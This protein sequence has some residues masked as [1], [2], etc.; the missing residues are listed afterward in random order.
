VIISAGMIFDKA[1]FPS[2]HAA[3]LVETA[4]GRMLAAWFGGTAE[5]AKDVKIWASTYDGK[6]WSAPVVAAEEPGQPT[7]NPVLFLGSKKTLF[8]FYKAGPSPERWSGFVRRSRDQGRTWSKAEIL[9]AGLLGPIKNK[10]IELADGV[11]LAPTSVESYRAWCCW[12]ERSS[13]DGRTWQRHGP[14]A[15]PDKPHG[16]IQPTLLVTSKGSILALCRSRGIG[17]IC[18]AESKDDGLTWSDAKPTTLPNPNSGIDAVRARDWSFYLVYNPTKVGRSPLVLARSVDDGQ[19]WK[20]VATLDEMLLGEFSYPAIIQAGDGRLHMAWTWNR[21]HI[22][23]AVY[24]P[25][26]K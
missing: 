14:I 8:L 25:G 2:C 4:P 10:P 15:V 22:K 13:D 6:R 18:G 26:R 16:L 24:E 12:V 21:R 9:P 5:G 7:W 19:T 1:P 3:T 17:Y 11:I 20:T 23:H